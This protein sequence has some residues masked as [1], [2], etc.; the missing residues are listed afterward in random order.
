MTATRS[1]ARPRRNQGSRRLGATAL[2]GSTVSMGCASPGCK[3]RIRPHLFL[4]PQELIVL[5][6]PLAARD[7]ADL[8]LAAA[9]GHRQVRQGG[10]LRLTAAGGDYRTVAGRPRQRDHVACL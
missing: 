5:R 10:V 9:A 1:R 3:W 2:A 4:D 8:D 7:G 6:Q